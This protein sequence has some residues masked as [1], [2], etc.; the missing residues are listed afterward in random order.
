MSPQLEN[1]WMPARRSERP[2]FVNLQPFQPVWLLKNNIIVVVV[3]IIS[4]HKT[5]W[6]FGV[7]YRWTRVRVLVSRDCL[8][9]NIKSSKVLVCTD[10]GISCSKRQWV[11]VEVLPG[12]SFFSLPPID[13]VMQSSDYA[14]HETKE[15]FYSAL[16]LLCCRVPQRSELRSRVVLT[17][18]LCC[19]RRAALLGPRR[20]VKRCFRIRCTPPPLFLPCS[21]IEKRKLKYKETPKRLKHTVHCT[22]GLRCVLCVFLLL[23]GGDE[24]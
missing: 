9:E 4:A 22:H 3:I 23:F 21:C 5:M 1:A 16:A 14:V 11:I 10:K 18:R 2:C 17:L 19:F 13:S 8:L 15:C 12:V 7:E 20:I 24:L 6:W